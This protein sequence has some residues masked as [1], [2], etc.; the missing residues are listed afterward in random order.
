MSTVS[1]IPNK[2]NQG[3]SVVTLID[4]FQC[5]GNSLQI[6]ND[7]FASLS[8]TLM[9]LENYASFWN[10]TYTLFTAN[11]A[12]WFV[13]S[14]HLQ[15]YNSLWNQAYTTVNTLSA[16]W[17][18]P[19]TVYYPQLILLD[20]WYSKYNSYNNSIIPTWIQKNFPTSKYSPNQI[21][22]IQIN[23]YHKQPFKFTFSRNLTEQCIPQGGVT[24]SCEP[25]KNPYHGCNHHGGQA[26]EGPCTNAY[27]DCNASFTADK[28]S[29]FSCLG[30]GGKTLVINKNLSSEDTCVARTI[31]LKY[32]NINNNWSPI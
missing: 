32:K 28:V 13:M 29:S 3:C 4:E 6:I 25:C 7:N 9:S 1:N 30:T 19:F 10:D 26:G 15:Q 17:N 18:S 2:T 14:S 16:N 11:S 12:N 27:K 24:L 5:V 20:E 23:L 31:T 8:G 21:V 22:I